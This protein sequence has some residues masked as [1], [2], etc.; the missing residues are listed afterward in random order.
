[1]AVVVTSFVG[2]IVYAGRIASAIDGMAYD[3]GEN[4]APSVQYLSAA[5][6]QLFSMVSTLAG[7]FVDPTRREEVRPAIEQAH[8]RLHQKLDAYL[9]LPFFPGERAR[10]AATGQAVEDA[11]RAINHVVER[12]EHGDLAGAESVR[13]GE[14][15]EAV[16]R[17]DAALEGSVSFDAMEGTRLSQSIQALR[18][19]AQHTLWI[20]GVLDVL[21]AFSLME[22]A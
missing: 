3:I 19:R 4:A 6:T 15:A 18:K 14:M 1:T 10:Y 16:H 8:V 11:E 7:A 12:L 21:L 17:A 5:R 13:Y 9:S 20:L 2:S 22:I